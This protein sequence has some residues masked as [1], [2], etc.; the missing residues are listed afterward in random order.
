MRPIKDAEGFIVNAAV[1][2]DSQ[3]VGRRVCCPGCGER[4]FKSW[5]GGWDGHAQRCRG[6]ASTD[7]ASR[8]TEFKTAFRA[9]FRA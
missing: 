8:K 9:L 3:V 4:I 1:L 7:E 2:R 5:P 6:L